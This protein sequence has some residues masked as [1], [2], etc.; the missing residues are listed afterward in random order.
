[1]EFFFSLQL[2]YD[3]TWQ[4]LKEK[5]SHCGKFGLFVSLIHCSDRIV[6]FVFHQDLAVNMWAE[7]TTCSELLLEM[8]L[9]V[10]LQVR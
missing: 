10:L 3:L 5:F 7:S 8:S 4:K 1:M 2:S 6:Y 9:A